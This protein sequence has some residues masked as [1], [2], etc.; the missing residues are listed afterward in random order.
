MLGWLEAIDARHPRRIERIAAVLIALAALA[1][2]WAF[3]ASV[4][5]HAPMGLPLD[6]SYAYL[7]DARQL[8][9]GRL[10]G[11]AASAGFPVGAMS[12]LWPIALA[13]LWAL[14]ARGH[15]L[16]WASFA[17]SAVFYAATG[18]AAGRAVTALIGRAAAPLVSRAAGLFAALLV[19]ASSAFAWGALSGTEVAI[20]GAAFAALIAALAGASSAGPIEARIAG[21]IDG[22]PPLGVALCLAALALTRPDAALIA[23]GIAVAAA[24]GR[25]RRHGIATAAAW[26]APIAPAALWLIVNRAISGHW[27]PAPMIAAS[28]GVAWRAV[29]GLCGQVLRSAFWDPASPLGWPRTIAALWLLGAIRVLVRA[30][31][32]RRWLAGGA[33]V[34]APIAVLFAAA[35]WSGA[36][37]AAQLGRWIAPALP[38]VAITA[39]TALAPFAAAPRWL[40]RGHAV[41]AAALVLGFVAASVP[42]LMR[43][44]QVYAQAATDLDAQG[45]AIGEYLHRKLPGAL[46]AVHRPGAIGYYSDG[47]IYDLADAADH[48]PGARFERLEALPEARRFGHAVLPPGWLGTAELDGADLYHA[49][50]ARPF[51]PRLPVDP[52]VAVTAMNWDHVGSAERP[53]YDHAGWS[54]VDRIDVA[55]LASEAAH[56]WGG[57]LGESRGL[58]DPPARWS[59]VAREARGR[60][61][62]LDGGRTIRGGREQFRFTAD[63][64]R[65]VRLVLRAGGAPSYPDQERIAGASVVRVLD[66]AGRELARATVPPPSADGSFV[67]V[68]FAIAAG[69][70]TTVH[71]EASAAYRAFHWFVLQ[72]E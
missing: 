58:A 5:A 31:R 53:L 28:A 65:P 66:D 10:T 40:R 51:A 25:V 20:C 11:D 60:G 39:G 41:V 4:L 72:P 44:A 33:L 36:A 56:H 61:L 42:R 63:P 23:L 29:P 18:L 71:T 16:V 48:G 50:L 13:P 30:R 45:V 27:L 3:A 49:R 7:A 37:F 2:V 12:A 52:D 54:I 9:R 1:V 69:A 26:L 47:P 55:D 67:E 62:L 14:G 64:A 46:I 17:L 59:F 38:L 70:P 35:A 19:V 8:A 57:A 15:A 68:A 6:D 21:P 22:P 34:A 32:E 24:A 43:D